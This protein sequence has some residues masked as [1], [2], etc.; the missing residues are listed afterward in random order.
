MPTDLVKFLT[1]Q[2]GPQLVG[3]VEQLLA[4]SEDEARKAVHIAIPAVL[5]GFAQLA[6]TPHGATILSRAAE[7]TCAADVEARG[8]YMLA[9]HGLEALRSLLRQ[10]MLE[11]L[12]SALGKIAGVNVS[13]GSL[14]LGAMAP[15]T[16]ICLR[17]QRASDD[18]SARGYAKLL[19]EQ[20][21]NIAA[22]MPAD[23]SQ[24]IGS[25]GLQGGTALSLV[26][27][28]TE[29]G[30]ITRPAASPVITMTKR[31]G[32]TGQR[33]DGGLSLIQAMGLLVAG[34]LIVAIS[35]YIFG[36]RMPA[37]VQSSPEIREQ[38]A[39]PFASLVVD[40][41]DLGTEFGNGIIRLGQ[42][43]TGMT[44]IASAKAAL[45]ALW[46]I[47][48]SFNKITG[49]VGRLPAS[50]QARV[51]DLAAKAMPLLQAKFNKACAIPGVAEV[52]NPVL[53]RLIASI[54]NFARRFT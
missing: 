29:C 21:A 47:S 53:G 44:D 18:Q 48:N 10:D 8:P 25:K 23:L 2:M 36:G 30:Q 26:A 34:V 14:L 17:Q 33:T 31:A 20:R 52:L 35:Q 15:A 13:G 11:S 9:Q 27:D 24:L 12:A 50:G 28:R 45:P 16:L 6:A 39:K 32:A 42:T 37:A 54:G 1:D 49:L 51:A 38:A 5:A 19:S 4:M 7:Q 41:V 46:E 40:D 43:L 3:S 22:A